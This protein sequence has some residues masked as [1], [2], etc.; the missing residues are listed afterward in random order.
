MINPEAYEDLLPPP[1]EGLQSTPREP[2]KPAEPYRLNF[3]NPDSVMGYKLLHFPD[4][5]PGGLM[6][7]SIVITRDMAAMPL[8]MFHP[9]LEVGP[10]SGLFSGRCLYPIEAENLSAMLAQYFIDNPEVAVPLAPAGSETL[11]VKIVVI[12][13]AE[14]DPRDYFEIAVLPCD[15]EAE[16]DE[17]DSDEE[18]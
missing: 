4:R 5:D 3:S 9:I 7:G 18:E 10:V 13:H 16:D 14:L 12:R 2:P 17:Q 1:L 8:A 6:I 15:P 11:G